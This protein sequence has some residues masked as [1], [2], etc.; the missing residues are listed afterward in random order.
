MHWNQKLGFIL[1]IRRKSLEAETFGTDFRCMDD[2]NSA[3]TNI[4]NLSQK[5]YVIIILQL[6]EEIIKT[7]QL[8]IAVYR[9]YMKKLNAHENYY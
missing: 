3:Q 7:W 6:L 2:K 4:K 9:F 8:K 5:W 1:S